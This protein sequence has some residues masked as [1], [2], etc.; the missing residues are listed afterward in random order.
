MKKNITSREITTIDDVES[1]VSLFLSIAA[2]NE[3]DR[4]LVDSGSWSNWLRARKVMDAKLSEGLEDVKKHG[5]V[6]QKAASLFTEVQSIISGARHVP[7]EELMK[8]H[9]SAVADSLLSR[10]RDFARNR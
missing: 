4:D 3:Q 8:K 7:S 2:E 6:T 9:D 5:F 10:I 1:L